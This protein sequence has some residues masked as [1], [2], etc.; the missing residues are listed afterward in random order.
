MRVGSLTDIGKIRTSNEDSLGIDLERGIFIVADGMG[1]H[2]AGEV[3][4]HRAVESIMEALG[5]RDLVEPVTD[6]LRQAVTYANSRIELA[7]QQDR[8]LKGMG[9]TV[10]TAIVM[11]KHKRFA[12]AHV[13][14]SRAYL[15][16][17]AR[18]QQLTEDHSMV[19]EL[20]RTGIISPEAAA[21]HPYRSAISRSLGQCKNVEVDIIEGDWLEED[22]LLLCTDG[23]TRFVDNTE[24]IEC[25][26]RIED[27]QLACKQLVDLALERGGHDNITVILIVHTARD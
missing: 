7:A 14:D 26:L 6:A 12:I 11:D 22:R 8:N 13:G 21:K 24:L 20:V 4:S 17:K 3:A 9:T 25:I 2:Q 27:P 23:L 15:I 18:I 10:V 1:G 5:E 16:R 19:A